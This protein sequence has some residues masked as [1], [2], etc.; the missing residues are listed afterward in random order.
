MKIYVTHVKHHVSYMQQYVSHVKHDV[1]YMERG[2]SVSEAR[3]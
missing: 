2:L 1:S 3:I